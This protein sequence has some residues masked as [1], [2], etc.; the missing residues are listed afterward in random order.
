MS[1]E[2]YRQTAAQLADGRWTIGYGHTKSA[3]EGASVSR[4]DARALL[5][6]DLQETVRA[7]NDWVYSPITQNQFDALASFAFNICLDNFRGSVVLRRVNEG[8][9]LQAAYA[10]EMW[11]RA[12]LEGESMVVDALVRRRAAEKTLFLTPPTGWVAAPRAVVRPTVDEDIAASAPRSR[13]VEVTTAL[14]GDRVTAEVVRDFPRQESLEL[15][16]AGLASSVVEASAPDEEALAEP[17]PSDP[18]DKDAVEAF[19]EVAET[20]LA[21]AET[22][23]PALEH[24]VSAEPAV[25]EPVVAEILAPEPEA[26]EPE[27]AP[28]SAPKPP[29]AVAAT[30][31]EAPFH[32]F[33]PI[34]SVAAAELALDGR[35]ASVG[36]AGLPAWAEPVAAPPPAEGA[37][38]PALAERAAFR[39][40]STTRFTG[41]QVVQQELDPMSFAPM[42]ALGLMGLVLFAGA[43][44]WGLN[45]HA[46]RGPLNPLTI[47]ALIALL[48][49]ACVVVAV[50]S[51]VT[52]YLG[53][54][55]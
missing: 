6:Y 30:P 12:D 11:R 4:D 21:D 19:P 43:V 47:G 48:G 37:P 34:G 20:A 35:P 9:L 55:E 28:I 44:I 42:A 16:V 49:I 52:R 2:G 3:R 40:P 23:E 1:F 15:A 8:E 54:D 51:V 39:T 32:P 5:I 33:D 17:P 53:R 27:P 10:L 26:P 38:N 36:A 46:A 31:P 22:F 18:F 50:Y 13:P 29:P 45:A 41:F 7:V 25:A 24:T 14:V